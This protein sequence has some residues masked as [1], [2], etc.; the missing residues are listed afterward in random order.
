MNK[1]KKIKTSI[2]GLYIIEP[3]VFSDNRGFFLEAYNMEEFKELGLNCNFVQDNHSKSK[4]GVLRGLHFQNKH[5]QGKLIRVIKGAV[6][7]VAVDIRKNSKTYGKWEGI[8][9]S[10][11]N[12][13]MLYIEPGFAHGFLTLEE[14]TEILYKCTDIYA[15]KYDR[16]ITYNDKDLNIDWKFDEFGIKD[17]ILSEKDKKHQSFNE[18]TKS[19]QGEFVLITGGNGQLGQ[20]F[21]KLFDKIGIKYIATDY[22]ILDITNKEKV[23]DYIDKYDFDV[24]INCAAYNDVDKAE[25]EKDRCFDLNYKAVENLTQI[26]KERDIIFVT[27]STDF[28]F[29]GNSYLP[30]TE[31]DASNPLSNYAK[32]K[33]MGENSAIEYEKALVIRT[34]WVFGMGNNNF[35]K[36]VINWA[37]DRNYL[38]IVDDQVSSPTYSKDLAY[39]SWELIKKDMYGL[40]HFSND[41]EGCKYDQAKYILDKIGWQGKLERASSSEFNLLARRP[42]YSKLNSE[43]IRK[44]V[45]KEIPHWKDAIDRFFIEL[46]IENK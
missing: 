40:F 39:F 24:V 16:G 7:D 20:D 23:K 43:K 33:L 1:F 9:L 28:V 35:C 32:A 38:R 30:Y 10:E 12:K 13:K 17:I 25:I 3:T 19:Y 6:Y 42:K 46:Q 21:Q 22:D 18:Y 8:V 15:P 31:K 26:C 11:E 34:S 41:G 27:Y 4:K 44:V 5:P 37:K 29:D 2:E 14:D 36:Q 45:D